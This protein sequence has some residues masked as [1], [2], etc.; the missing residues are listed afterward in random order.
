M[1]P[2]LSINKTSQLAL[3]I[4]VSQPILDCAQA[5]APQSGA[6]RVSICLP[7]ARQTNWSA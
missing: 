1:R 4:P 7:A 2:A 6:L 3:E 5:V